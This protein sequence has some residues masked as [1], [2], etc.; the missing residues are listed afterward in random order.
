V[1]GERLLE[2]LLLLVGLLLPVGLLLR[3]LLVLCGRRL[4][5]GRRLGG[6][7]VPALAWCRPLRCPRSGCPRSGGSV[8]SRPPG[9]APGLALGRD[10][11]VARG[12]RQEG[13]AAVRG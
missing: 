5:G 9:A 2:G 12:A 3:G 1:L 6:G 13:L 8:L 7:R 4:L 11:P 10:R